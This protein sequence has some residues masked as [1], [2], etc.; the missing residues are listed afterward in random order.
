MQITWITILWSIL[1]LIS[2]L[3]L[4]L[5]NHGRSTLAFITSKKYLLLLIV[6]SLFGMR[7]QLG[8]ATSLVFIA[9]FLMCLDYKPY[10]K[11]TEIQKIK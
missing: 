7:E 5:F 11:H 10:I 1:A 6:A 4:Y 8:I 3:G 9:M 2:V